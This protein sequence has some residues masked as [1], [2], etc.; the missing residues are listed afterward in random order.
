MS[1]DPT[2]RLLRASWTSLA[3]TFIF[4]RRPR[5]VLG[6]FAQ[7]LNSTLSRSLILLMARYEVVVVLFPSKTVRW[8]IVGNDKRSEC[9][10]TANECVETCRLKKSVGLIG[11]FFSFQRDSETIRCD[12]NAQEP[13]SGRLIRRM[14]KRVYSSSERSVP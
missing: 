12:A 14:D 7:L 5:S 4:A 1:I 10:H 11:R 2:P 8:K 3:D 13:P 9:E 6:P